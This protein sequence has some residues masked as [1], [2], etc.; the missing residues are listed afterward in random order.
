[1]SIGY[2]VI[3]LDGAPVGDSDS[4]D[5]I[6]EIVKNA[7]SGRYRIQKVSL[8]P[9]TGEPRSWDWGAVTKSRKGRIMLD[10]PPWMD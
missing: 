8:D 10:L 2:R 3:S 9:D 4:I 6:V 1:M 5:G 7:A